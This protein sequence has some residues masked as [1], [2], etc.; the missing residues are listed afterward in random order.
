MIKCTVDGDKVIL[1]KD[2]IQK[3]KEHY[4]MMAEKYPRFNLRKFYYIGMADVL[5]DLIKQ[6]DDNED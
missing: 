4:F 2:D 5:T 6:I 3:Q 1:T